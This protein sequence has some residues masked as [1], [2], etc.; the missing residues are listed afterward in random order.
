MTKGSDGGRS[1]IASK[2]PRPVVR[3]AHF[4]S[5]QHCR[6]SPIRRSPRYKSLPIAIATAKAMNADTA[7]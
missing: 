5:R 7:K 1:M 2:N 3:S 6:E 4:V